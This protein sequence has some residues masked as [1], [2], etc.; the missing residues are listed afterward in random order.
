[1]GQIV[2]SSISFSV[3]KMPARNKIRSTSFSGSENLQLRKTWNVFFTPMQGDDLIYATSVF[4]ITKATS[5]TSERFKWTANL[6]VRMKDE[7]LIQQI[8][9]INQYVA[10]QSYWLCKFSLTNIGKGILDGSGHFNFLNAVIPERFFYHAKRNKNP[11]H[12]ISKFDSFFNLY[13]SL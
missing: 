10:C 9:K 4:S 11:S 1:M 5:S 13:V 7:T 8:N 12:G 6:H 2:K 3:S